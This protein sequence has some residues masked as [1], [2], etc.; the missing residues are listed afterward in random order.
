MTVRRATTIPSDEQVDPA[1][2]IL[3]ADGTEA[4]IG[5]RSRR[6]VL[7][8]KKPGD[9]VDLLIE[10]PGAGEQTVTVVLSESPDDPDAPIVGFC[11]F[12]TR[13]VDLPFEVDIRT[14]DIG[15]PSAGW[16]SRWR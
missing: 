15:G 9:E 6:R 5:R 12:D 1:D 7:A 2:T 4:R 13:V 3:E 11:P 14:D 16:R 8:D 10:R